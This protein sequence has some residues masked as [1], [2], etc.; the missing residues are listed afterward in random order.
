MALMVFD[1]DRFHR[2]GMR[3]PTLQTPDLTSAKVVILTGLKARYGCRTEGPN[4]TYGGP[5]SGL[6]RQKR[7]ALNLCLRP[8]HERVVLGSRHE[9]RK[10][11]ARDLR[12][13]YS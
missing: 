4:I 3:R 6:T 10:R 8:F 7:G 11:N 5:R 2:L 12:G 13:N 1:P 9:Y